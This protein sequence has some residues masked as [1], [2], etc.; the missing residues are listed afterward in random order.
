MYTENELRAALRHSASRADH[1]P[2]VAPARSASV[3]ALPATRRP[4]RRGLVTAVAAV[5]AVGAVVASTAGL[6]SWLDSGDD[7]SPTASPISAAGTD[8]PTTGS[9]PTPTTPVDPHV[10]LDISALVDTVTLTPDA[11][12][13]ASY[14]LAYNTGVE[15]ISQ[16]TGT[17]PYDPQLTIDVASP[18]SGLDP[19]R[20]PRD[21][22]MVIA[23]TTGYYGKVKIFPI[24]GSTDPGSDKWG[25][26][27]TIAFPHGDNWV[28]VWLSTSGG[29]LDDPDQI[30]Q[31]YEQ[32][33]VTLGVSVAR[34][35][36]R[37]GWLPDGLSVGQVTF[38]RAP[39]TG[40]VPANGATI[41]LTASDDRAIFLLVQSDQTIP[42]NCKAPS[43]SESGSASGG[44]AS[45]PAPV[46][47]CMPNREIGGGYVV[48]AQARG[49]DT[50]T[51]Q[52]IL[53]SITLADLNNPASFFTLAEALG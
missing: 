30:A 36:F 18:A 51:L 21:R 9:P 40:V 41:A 6:R 42:E 11:Q 49:F 29:S 26:V 24:D 5:A 12:M 44:V 46:S 20:I 32:Y 1:L 4:R 2:D 47:G 53:D 33:G 45:P 39:Q 48:V 14:N 13:F 27:W 17:G 19:S 34:L 16:P 8:S 22:P 52:R 23:G 37:T 35:P 31:L 3:S 28:F 38:Q 15:V 7:G 50:A 43:A 10:S 25:P